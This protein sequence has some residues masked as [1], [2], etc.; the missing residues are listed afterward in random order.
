MAEPGRPGRLRP[1]HRRSRTSRSRRT[2]PSSGRTCRSTTRRSTRCPAAPRRSRPRSSWPGPTTWPAAR[3]TGSSCSAAGGATTATRSGR[4]TCRVASRSVARTRAGSAASATSARRTRTGPATRAR[5][6]SRRPTS[7]PPSSS[8]RSS[9]PG[10]V[11]VAAFVA[12]PIVGA[13]LAAAV[14]P[15][16]YWPAIA[17]V[18]RRHGVLLIADEVM[19]GFGRTGRW[20]G[21]DHWGVR[22]DLLVGGQGRDF[23]LLAVRVRGRVRHRLRD[24]HGARR[25]VRP[26]VHLQ[27]PRG[28]APPS[29]ARSCRCSRPSRSSRPARRRAS[30]CA[31]CVDERLADHPNVGEIRGRGLMIG[32]E[33]VADRDD[34]RAVPAGRPAD[35]DDR[36]DRP[37]RRSAALQR[38]GPGQ[39]RRRRLDPPRAA[40]RRDRRRARADRRRAGGSASTRRSATPVADRHASPRPSPTMPSVSPSPP[41]SDVTMGGAVRSADHRI[42][43]ARRLGRLAR[44]RRRPAAPAPGTPRSTRRPGT[45]SS[46]RARCRGSPAPRSPRPTARSAS[47]SSSAGRGSS[48]AWLFLAIGVVGGLSNYIWGYVGLGLTTGAAPGPLAVVDV[49]WLNNVLTYPIWVALAVL[50]VLLFPDGRPL[51]RR[52]RS[53]GR[54]PWSSTPSCSGVAPGDR[55]RSRCGS[56]RSTTRCPAPASTGPIVAIRHPGRDSSAC[57]SVGGPG[58][59]WGLVVRY[60]P[61]G[62]IERRQLKWFAW[63]SVLTLAGGA[64]LVV[65]RARR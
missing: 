17:E 47:C 8:G 25:R 44:R 12:E 18:C 45:R 40:V 30:G 27:P 62:P 56:S 32:V 41:A 13:T 11:R 50:L 31:S 24:G 6:P 60:R 51:D 36:P 61:P 35:R 38:D 28:R 49:A 26:R 53:G 37:R 21:L 20:F 15:D 7:S 59:L 29:P 46:S 23:G 52:W 5:T 55:A 34:A 3:P 48:I 19:T 54:S 33:L 58:S 39:R 42:E 43:A 64:V 2:P 16:G 65:A 10:R 9:R 4:S 14:P 1:R 22:P 63:G 57:A